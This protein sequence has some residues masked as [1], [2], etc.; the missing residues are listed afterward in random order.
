M[1]LIAIWM[2]MAPIP[3]GALLPRAVAVEFTIVSVPFAKVDAV[4][5]IFA[6]IPLMVVPMVAIVVAVMIA[7]VMTDYHFLGSGHPGC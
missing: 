6:V 4:G 5:M 7:V 3:I 1:V 2:A